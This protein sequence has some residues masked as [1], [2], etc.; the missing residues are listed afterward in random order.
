MFKTLAGSSILA[1]EVC[2]RSGTCVQIDTF[3]SRY[4]EPS[5]HVI[6]MCLRVYIY[7][8]THRNTYIYIYIFIHIYIYVLT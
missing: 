6:T 1:H 5:M 3:C 4:R 8:Y 7:V 2:A